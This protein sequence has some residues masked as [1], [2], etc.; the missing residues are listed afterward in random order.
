MQVKKPV[1]TELVNEQLSN[2]S[3]NLGFVTSGDSNQF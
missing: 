1:K 3:S 2:K